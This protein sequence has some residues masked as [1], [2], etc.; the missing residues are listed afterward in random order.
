MDYRPTVRACFTGYIVQAVVN[1]F[2][3]LLFLTFQARYGVPLSQVTLLITINFGLQLL[4]DTASAFFIDKIGYRACAF[5]ANAFAAL[6]LVLLTILPRVLPDP[7]V[8]LLLSV[9]FYAIGGGLLEVVVSPIVEACPSKHKAKTMSLLH[10]FYCWGSVGVI[11]LS[12]LF[13]AVAGTQHWRVLTLVWAILP[14]ANA[15]LFLFVPLA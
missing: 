4:I 13:F 15:V 7:F 3:P 5:L 8:G 1:N 14:A 12:A 10:S 2:A 9:L 11:S 6:G